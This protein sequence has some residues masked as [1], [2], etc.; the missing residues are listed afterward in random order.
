MRGSRVGIRSNPLRHLLAAPIRDPPGLGRH[1]RGSDPLGQERKSRSKGLGPVLDRLRGVFHP[2]GCTTLW[3]QQERLP[4]AGTRR[5][6]PK[7][8][9]SAKGGGFGAVDGC[10]LGRSWAAW[11]VASARFEP[12]ATE[13]W[14]RDPDKSG[15]S[16]L[17]V[18]IERRNCA[19]SPACLACDGADGETL[20]GACGFGAV[21]A[22]LQ[23]R[24]LF[25]GRISISDF[26]KHRDMYRD[27]RY[28]GISAFPQG[29]VCDGTDCLARMRSKSVLF[30]RLDR[31]SSLRLKTRRAG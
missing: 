23:S 13:I 6:G 16:T 9:S 2:C 20:A 22:A 4:V 28:V 25:L 27:A 8:I 5:L 18:D 12:A 3:P 26:R 24:P 14:R 31:R 30:G 10:I 7:C 1:N 17:A 21:D 11:H 15:Q 19:Q 29:S